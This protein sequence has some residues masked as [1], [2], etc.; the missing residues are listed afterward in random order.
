MQLNA[1]WVARGIHKRPLTPHHPLVAIATR[2]LMTDAYTVRRL[3]VLNGM[4]MSLTVPVRLFT[5]TVGYVNGRIPHTSLERVQS[6][7]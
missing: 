7:T 2:Q 6:G 1:Q 5:V 3:P 4:R